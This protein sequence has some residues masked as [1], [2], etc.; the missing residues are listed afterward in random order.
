MA[1]P[2]YAM[3]IVDP[4]LLI[5]RDVAD[6]DDGRYQN[7]M[8][9]RPITSYQ[10]GS[11]IQTKRLEDC[12]VSVMQIGLSCSAISPTERKQMYVVVNKMKATRDSYLN[13]R[14]R[15]QQYAR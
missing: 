15:S 12:L 8:R 7:D 4:S 1:M 10:D 6:V 2:D 3:D 13:L 9:A 14:R 11:P 5:E